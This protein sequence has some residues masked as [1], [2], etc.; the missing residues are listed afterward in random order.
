MPTKNKPLKALFIFGTRPEAI[1][2]A[3]LI[4]ALREKAQ[5]EVCVTAQHREMLDQVLGFFSIVPDYDLDVMRPDQTLFGL[6]AHCLQL[7]EGV[8]KKSAPGVVIVQGDT[9]TAFVGALAG[10]YSRTKVAHIE[11][12]LRSFDKHSPFPEEINRLLVSR[13]ADYHFAPTGKARQNLLDERVPEDNI[14]TVGNTVVDALF[15]GL[16]I[17]EKKGL[18]F[19][20]DFGG[21]DFSKRI[22]LVTG[23]RRESFGAPFEE[24]CGAIR[25]IAEGN[26]VEV[27][28][29]VHLNPNVRKHVFGLLSETKNIHLIE[30]LDYPRMIWLM[31]R[32]YLI[33][34][35]SGG[36][37]EEA[38][39][40]GKPVLVMRDVTER[41]EG[42]EQGTALLVGTDRQRIVEATERLL[43]DKEAYEKMSRAKN[44]YGDGTAAERI[45]E[46]LTRLA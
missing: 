18:D 41:M 29:P 5:V 26:D 35:D 1:K 44:P 7:L 13:M 45:A 3:P 12:G 2:L 17:I 32:C 22:V 20:G 23:H 43:N 28:Y 10:F 30:P 36:V 8:I 46:I 6:T 34:T 39:S 37:Q 25:E 11:A 33:L 19:K 40:L 16:G 27:V 14:F 15:A 31:N 38:P 4:L 24:I 21:V 9:T 42:V